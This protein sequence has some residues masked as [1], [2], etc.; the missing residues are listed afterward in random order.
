[1]KIPI[2]GG[3]LQ[4]VI[5]D[6]FLKDAKKH[7]FSDMGVYDAFASLDEEE[8]TILL[9]FDSKNITPGI[10]AHEAIHVMGFV[11]AARGVFYDPENDEPAAYFIN[12]VVDQVYRKIG[13]K[14][15]S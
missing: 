7:G 9:M 13:Q 10:V 11:F 6:N 8:D 5:S 1:M 3:K 14:S 12:W 15:K 4:I 2:Y